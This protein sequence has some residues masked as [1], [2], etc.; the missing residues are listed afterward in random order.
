MVFTRVPVFIVSAVTRRTSNTT[1]L[2]MTVNSSKALAVEKNLMY[3]KAT[4]IDIQ[5]LYASLYNT[6]LEAETC[7]GWSYNT[8]YTP[9]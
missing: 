3:A 6:T 1:A 5:N 7:C 8:S 4:D 2:A 9:N